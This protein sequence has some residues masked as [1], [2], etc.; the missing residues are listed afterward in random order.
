MRSM[1]P[2]ILFMLTFLTYVVLVNE[3]IHSVAP[4]R[5]RSPDRQP[6]T[7]ASSAGR[8]SCEPWGATTVTRRGRLARAAPSRTCRAR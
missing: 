1:R 8:T 2:T 6:A 3:R 4:K 5:R 7:R